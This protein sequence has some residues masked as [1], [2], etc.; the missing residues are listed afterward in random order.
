MRTL[1]SKSLRYFVAIAATAVVFTARFLL[2]PALGDVASLLLFILS[3]VVSAWHG[4]LGPG[5]LAT[6][7]GVAI[8]DYFFVEPYYSFGAKSSEERLDLFLFLCTGISISILSHARISA[9]AK[10]Q[11]LLVSERNARMAA[12]DANRLKDEFLS[13]VSHELRTPLTAING[14]AMMLRNGRLDSAQTARAL[15]TIVRNAK[16]QNQLIDDLLDVSRII[17]GKL[18]MDAAPLK[19]SSV[20]EAAVDT[21]RPAAD[22]KEI[23]LSAL[24]D[25]MAEKVTGD[26]ERLQQVVWNLLS[27]AVKFAPKGGRVEVRLERADSHVKIVVADNG[28]GIKPEFLPYVFEHF[29]QEDSGTNRQ[30]G[31]LGLGLAIVRHIVELHGGTVHAASEG[32]GKGA[33]FTVALPIAQGRA[34][35]PDELRGRA[36]G[37]NLAPENPPSL[38]GVRALFVDDE[39]DARE[40]IAM[41][42]AQVGAEVRTAASATEALAACDE[43]RPD[44]LISDIGMP[45]EDGYTLM[46][47]LRARESERGGHIPAIALTAYG[48]RE[49]CWRAL[50]VGYESHLSKPVEPAEL[51]T[52]VASLT[53]RIGKQ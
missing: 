44:V 5:L 25:P 8:T 6:A 48:R 46:K 50:S 40:L 49:D 10:R 19:L 16:A 3:V 11:Q 51:L 47:E 20:I 17:T 35:S 45:G 36:A 21:V 12:E 26:A 30:Q 34:V 32:L 38:E 53:N 7:L 29:R 33:I 43:W 15:E 41:M 2:D 37:G 1:L 4:G 13:T 27:N 14:W 9:E 22:A 42:L 52:V 31:G 24:L 28:Q 39:A 18:R 23:H